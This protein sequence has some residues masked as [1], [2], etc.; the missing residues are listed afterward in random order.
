MFQRVTNFFKYLAGTAMA[1]VA[2]AAAA[3]TTRTAVGVVAPGIG[4]AGPVANLA[5]EGLGVQAYKSAGSKLQD[6]II[7]PELRDAQNNKESAH[8]VKA[9]GAALATSA[10][11][12]AAVYP[13][14]HALVGLT[15]GGASVP[16]TVAACLVAEG[17]AVA[18]HDWA[19]NA[20]ENGGLE[21]AITHAYNIARNAQRNQAYVTLGEE[22][23]VKS[24]AA[25]LELQGIEREADGFVVLPNPKGPTIV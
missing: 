19:L 9:H 2:G 24:Y 13:A 15:T 7:N 3:A 4:L 10:I 11:T 14:A 8:S 12:R 5:A 16:A 21:N 23:S 6:T 17:S 18:A 1:P 20:A 22:E 25:Q